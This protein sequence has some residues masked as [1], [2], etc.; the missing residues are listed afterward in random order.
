MWNLISTYYIEH[1]QALLALDKTKNV[2]ELFKNYQGELLG[3]LT[4]AIKDKVLGGF[5]GDYITSRLLPFL[6]TPGP[7]DNIIRQLTVKYGET[8]D[9]SG[10]LDKLKKWTFDVLISLKN[11][12][13][14]D[15]SGLESRLAIDLIGNGTSVEN[16]KKIP[17]LLQGLLTEIKPKAFQNSPFTS[18]A[19]STFAN[20]IEKVV[21][22]TAKPFGEFVK[23]QAISTFANV[24]TIVSNSCTVTH[25]LLGVMVLLVIFF[26]LVTKKKKK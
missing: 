2:L 4:V 16:I 20:D 13:V 24:S 14:Q 1:S 18:I 9:L 8:K 25:V 21:V 22:T 6:K 11:N 23:D 19:T 26:G 17:S 15:E 10:E 12:V 5:S 7:E 3:E